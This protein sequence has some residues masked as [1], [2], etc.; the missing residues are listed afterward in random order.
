MK[1]IFDFAP[2][3]SELLDLGIEQ[4][5]EVYKGVMDTDSANA[6]LYRLFSLR[7]NVAVAEKHLSQIQNLQYKHDVSYCDLV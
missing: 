4:P 5:A 7:G 2:T 6:D 1:T 3:K